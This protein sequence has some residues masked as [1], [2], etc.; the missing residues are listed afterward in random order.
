LPPWLG[1]RQDRFEGPDE[2]GEAIASQGRNGNDGRTRERGAG[3]A[4]AHFFGYEVEPVLIDIVPFGEGDDT[5]LDLQEIE[6]R[7]MLKGL[8]H[9]PFVGGDDQEG[10]VDAADSSQHV[11]DEALMA[12]NVDD[13]DRGAA[14]QGEPGEAEIDR[15]L[16]RLFLGETIRVDAGQ[17]LD[18]GRLAVIDVARGP[19][20]EWPELN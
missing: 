2:R 20:H 15:H 3:D 18:E 17:G 5:V 16:A 1:I 13:A 8:G 14:G 11:L 4:L 9:G 10:R 19:N 12:R 6:N 7:Q